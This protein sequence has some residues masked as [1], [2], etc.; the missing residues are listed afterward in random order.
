MAQR[1]FQ[2]GSG[3]GRE[4]I[5]AR[6]AAGLKGASRHDQQLRRTRAKVCGHDGEHRY[7]HAL[8][9]DSA[10]IYH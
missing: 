6:R 7:Y 8:L 9:P 5:A 10:F 4:E 2:L 1:R 3:L